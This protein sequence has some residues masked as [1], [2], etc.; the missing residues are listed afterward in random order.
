MTNPVIELP[1][2]HRDRSRKLRSVLTRRI[3]RTTRIPGGA[4]VDG[5]G[6][7]S[8]HFIGF[9]RLVG[10]TAI[11]TTCGDKHEKRQNSNG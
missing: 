10:I 11:F 2:P 8:L 1:P 9:G 3:C 4:P 6:Y 5:T 7:R